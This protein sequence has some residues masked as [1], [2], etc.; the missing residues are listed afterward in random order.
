MRHLENI[1][2]PLLCL[3]M[4]VFI[5]PAYAEDVAGDNWQQMQGE[6]FIIYYRADVPDDFVQ[7]TMDCAEDEFKRV[8]D[9]LGIAPYENWSLD[10]RASI[11]IYSDQEDFVKNG[12]QVL[13]SHG[14]AFARAKV[15]K[16]F[17]E[18][19]GFF[20]AILPHELG[21]IVFREFVGFT[22]YVPL[23]FEE[24]MAV[25]QEKAKRLGA[26]KAVK[27]AIE[28]GQFIPLSKLSHMRLYI[29]SKQEL[30]EL[31]YAESASL[32]YFMITQLGQ[33]QFFML[34]REIKNNTPFDRALEKVYLRFKNLDE[35]NQA[36]VDYLQG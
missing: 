22:R 7:T 27:E 5:P 16:T 13:W 26:K 29:N 18:A 25:Y 8:M 17:P 33:Q 4:L 34:C 10:R 11:Y 30:V 32:V 12:H 2:R 23:W 9:D 36:W 35:L 20:D 21:H 15:I 19:Q 24:G 6:D 3:G 31:F 14:A 28:N 1:M